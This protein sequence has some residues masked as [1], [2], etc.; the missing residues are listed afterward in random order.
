MCLLCKFQRKKTT[1]S[2]NSYLKTRPV[3]L[4]R[5]EDGHGH[6]PLVHLHPQVPVIE[7]RVIPNSFVIFCSGDGIMDTPVMRETKAG[8]GDRSTDLDF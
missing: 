2:D 3:G 1:L 7:A 8:L 5:L 6:G 4:Q